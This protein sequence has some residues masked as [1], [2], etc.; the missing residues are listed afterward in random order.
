MRAKEFITEEAPGT[1]SLIPGCAGSLPGTFSLSQLTNADN[2]AQYRFGLNLAAARAAAAGEIEFSSQDQFGS[3]MLVVTQGKEDEDTLDMALAL[4]QRNAGTNGANKIT[5]VMVAD[6]ESREPKDTN[7]QSILM[8]NT[9]VLNKDAQAHAKRDAKK[10]K[11]VHTKTEKQIKEIDLIDVHKNSMKDYGV[12]KVVTKSKNPITQAIKQ[13][14]NKSS[15]KNT[16]TSDKKTKKAHRVS[17]S[18]EVR[19]SDKKVAN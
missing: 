2:Y 14:K 13:T 5:K 1:G 8:P 11:T 19:K 17:S 3:K 18:N 10:N 4:Y 6:R 9:R 7:V 15:N 16:G 12:S